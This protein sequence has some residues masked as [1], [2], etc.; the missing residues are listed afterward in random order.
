VKNPHL[1][2]HVRLLS[3]GSAIVLTV[4]IYKF[5]RFIIEH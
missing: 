1:N 5:I 4:E 2:L 3:I